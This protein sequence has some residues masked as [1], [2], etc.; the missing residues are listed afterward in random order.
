M[1]ADAGVLTKLSVL[2]PRADINPL[3]NRSPSWPATPCAGAVTLLL[4]GI[5]FPLRVALIAATVLLL[6]LASA[7]VVAFDRSRILLHLLVLPLLRLLLFFA[8]LWITEKG[9]PPP[10]AHAAVV[11]SNHVS[12]LW[13]GIYLVWRLGGP[14]LPAEQK[15]FRSPLMGLVARAVGILPF[16]RDAAGDM[17][18]RIGAAARA[19]GGPRVLLFPEGC[20]SNGGTVLKFK[21]GAFTPGLPVAPVALRFPLGP[22]GLDV[23]NAGPRPGLPRLLLRALAAPWTPMEVTWLPPLAPE[24]AP[25]AAAGKEVGERE[26]AAFAGAARAALAGALGVPLS[27][28]GL[29]DVNMEAAARATHMRPEDAIV[30]LGALS[31]LVRVAPWEAKRIVTEFA[32]VRP[33]ASRGSTIDFHQF[34]D[35]LLALRRAQK[36]GRAAPPEG[37]G[38][39]CPSPSA[40]LSRAAALPAGAAAPSDSASQ[41]ELSFLHRLFDMFDVRGERRRHPLFSLHQRP[42]RALLYLTLTPPPPQVRHEGRLDLREVLVGLALLDDRGVEGDAPGEHRELL[43]LAFGLLDED[44]SG[45]VGV[46]R[47]RR[48]FHAVLPT[49]SEERVA[50]LFTAAAGGGASVSEASFIAWASQP[51]VF[52]VVLQLRERFFGMQ[53]SDWLQLLAPP[54]R[55]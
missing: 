55:S 48:V 32:G 24:A 29:D 4:G 41:L 23:A 33:D 7:V 46:E 12:G 28:F 50:E 2:P 40:L 43:R 49:L 9:S 31:G 39:D 18:R 51:G 34:A 54:K 8:G 15:N 6:A 3:L 47:I 17:R 44:G 26:A 5:L 53:Q 11:V 30:E 13:D 45:A 37:G 22:S 52:P 21:T 38:G 10:R 14:T 19:A 25:G 27:T 35:L 20:C 1:A 42:R 36:A 16:D